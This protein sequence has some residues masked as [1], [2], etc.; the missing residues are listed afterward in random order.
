MKVLTTSTNTQTIKIIPRVYDTS[1]TI[2]LRDDSTND[3]VSF[4]LPTTI[5]NKGYLELSSIF[6]LKEGRFYDVKVYQIKGSYEE[7]KTRVIALG[8]TFE[9]NTCLLTFLESENLVNTTDLDIIYK[10]KIF[11]TNQVIDQDINKYY[12]VNKDVYTS[13]G[14]N[15]D[16]IML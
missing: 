10:D 14:G 12:S 1:V 11:C 2:K 16:Y 7:F 4:I 8:G 5:I 15:N 9:N 13:K 3:E 6:N